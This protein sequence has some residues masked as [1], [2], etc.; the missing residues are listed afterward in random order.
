[1]RGKGQ[2]RHGDQLEPAVVDAEDVIALEVELHGIAADL[3]VAGGIA[4]AQVAVAFIE[5]EQMCP[6]A[7]G[8]TGPA[9]EWAPWTRSAHRDGAAGLRSHATCPGRPARTPSTSLGMH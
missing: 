3:L 8:G 5:L 2:V 7:R 4:E 9:S 1:M 6:F